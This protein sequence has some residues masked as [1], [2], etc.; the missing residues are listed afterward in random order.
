MSI[1]AGG[2]N[3]SS[4]ST[5]SADC[6]IV[7]GGVVGRSIALELHARG[8]EVILLD[9]RRQPGV[10]SI[11]AAG[12]LAVDDPHNPA[13][14]KPLSQYSAA[15]YPAFLQRIAH[16]SG[17]L[18]P[19]QTD[20]TVQYLSDG[21]NM[22]LHEHSID[23]RQLANA[24]RLAI[25]N[26]TVQVLEHTSAES[27]VPSANGSSVIT[28]QGATIRAKTIV[29]SCGAWTTSA[30][31]WL[32]NDTLPVAP[33]KGQMLRVRVPAATPLLEVRRNEHVYIVPRS[34]GDQAGSALVG[35]TVE[36]AGFDTTLRA[37][38]ISSLRRLAADLWPAADS[39]AEVP[40]I[41]AWAGL[42][43]C[44]PDLL[45]VLGE[46]PRRGHFIATGHYRNGILLAPATA[47]VIADLIQER[48]P[49]TDLTA[50]SPHR[51][52]M[53]QP[54]VRSAAH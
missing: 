27:C 50:F 16:L 30:L 5:H 53:G 48:V 24:L 36:D 39:A 52:A 29:F 18:I 35:A 41:E 54:T 15:L 42:R 14:I 3:S 34:E 46:L 32:G 37:N 7:G 20:A 23:P 4:G 47:A 26:T 19:Y 38:A 9:R 51:F 28:S 21:S 43:P 45:P 12:M 11:A 10:A 40:L 2:T 22:R 17:T 49:E 44:T 31:A 1:E 13:A 25:A 33:R 6:I 8:A